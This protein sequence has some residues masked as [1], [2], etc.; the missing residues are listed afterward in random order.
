MTRIPPHGECS[1]LLVDGMAA[2]GVEITVAT[3]LPEVI[4]PYTS[5]HTCPHGTTFWIEPTGEQIA[6]WVRE[7]TP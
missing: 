5:G 6:R 2:L 4:S 1:D 7:G 3:E